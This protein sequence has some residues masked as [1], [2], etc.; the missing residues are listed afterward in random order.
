MKAAFNTLVII[1][2]VLSMIYIGGVDSLSTTNVVLYGAV[3]AGLWWVVKK[4]YDKMKED[5]TK[6]ADK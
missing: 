1:N 3:L 2:L 5:T 4:M 6:V